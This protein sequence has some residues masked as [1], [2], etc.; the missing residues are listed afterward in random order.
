MNQ[1]VA[2][3]SRRRLLDDAS[4]GLGTTRGPHISIRGGRF[5]WITAAAERPVDTHYID[6]IVVDAN[7]FDAR[8]YFDGPY[9]PNSDAPPECFSDNGSGPSKDAMQPQAP[10]C[11]Q[12]PQN[13]RGTD[14]TFTGKPTTAC[15]KRKKLGVI[16]AD[17]G[18]DIT[19]YE[20]VVTPGSLSNFKAYTTWLATQNHP[21]Q[22]RPC[23]ICDVVTR[24]EFDPQK[25]FTMLFS[26]SAWA[27]DDISLQKVEYIFNKDLGAIACGRNDVAIDP[28][29]FGALPRPAAQA[30]IAAPQPQPAQH[31]LPPRQPAQQ[32]VLP[33]PTNG[34]AQPR[35]PRAPRQPKAQAQLPA[36][37]PASAPFMSAATPP[38]QPAD[39]QATAA[40]ANGDIPAFLR[41]APDNSVP[42]TPASPAR[43]GIAQAPPPPAEIASAVQ[44][45]M[46]LPSRR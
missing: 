29:V 39:G 7:R 6:V 2:V 38:A 18:Q 33:P 22:N 4:A 28:N 31:A 32:Q 13:V 21:T 9:D 10:T 34:A 25:Q 14:V 26:C 11:L 37:A 8:V 46:S 15:T 42:Q 40:G 45:A 1:Q 35:A 44:Q 5:R 3:P 27:D 30:A 20:F 41:R 23:D 17:G 16:E 36:G 43:F 24:I 19:V 12:C